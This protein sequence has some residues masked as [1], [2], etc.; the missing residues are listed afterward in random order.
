MNI[1]RVIALFTIL[2]IIQDNLLAVDELATFE[3]FYVEESYIGWII[4]GIAAVVAGAVIF[5]TGGTASPIVIGVGTW[6]GEMAGLSGVAAT[7]YG[8]ALLGGG[9]IAS[10]GLGI[11]GG[12]AVVTAA[13]SFST[14]VVLDYTLGNVISQYSY[15]QFAKDSKNMPTLPIPQNE[16]GTDGYSK[17]VEYL[18]K[19]INTKENLFSKRN[20]DILEYLKYQFNLDP[21]LGDDLKERV[22]ESYLYFV[23]NQYSEAKI[24]AME[25][26][27]YAREQEIRRTLPA[28][29]YAT[30]TLYDEDFYFY[31]ITKNFFRYSV[32]A[33]P[34]NKFIPLMF[35]IYLDRVLYRMN[36]GKLNYLALNQLRDIS[37]EIEDD[38]LRT[39]S[40]VVVMMRY[41]IRIKIEQQKILSL[42]KTTNA[43]IKNSAKTLDIVKKSYI[44]YTNLIEN[45]KV[46]LDNDEIQSYIQDNEKLK[47]LNI[48]YARYEESSRYLQLSIDNLEQYQQEQ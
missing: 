40:M 45:I 42:T 27:E 24:K 1:I 22:L 36:D 15:N 25:S 33:E 38:D 4:A 18:K 31:N 6:I 43:I 8:L 37:F 29:I 7:N 5:F 39:Q 16:S 9:S 35:A 41:F 32:L 34:D 47:N 23:T 46:I 13:L 12:V 30:S 17:S 14:D 10:G 44:E 28:F 48:L 11:A 3:S 19:N 20:R 2:F 21:L 26:I